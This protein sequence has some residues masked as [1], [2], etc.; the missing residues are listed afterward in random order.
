[1]GEFFFWLGW[2][3]WGDGLEK[4]SEGLEG[5]GKGKKPSIFS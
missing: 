5:L 2:L 1:M 3:C 4:F